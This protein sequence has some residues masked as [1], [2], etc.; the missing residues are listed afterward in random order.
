MHMDINAFLT[1]YV[2]Y[3]SARLAHIVFDNGVDSLK[4][5]F[6]ALQCTHRG[7]AT[8]KPSVR[9]SVCLSLSVKRVDCDKTKETCAHILY[10][11]K[12]HFILVFWEERLVGAT[13]STYNF[14]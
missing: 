4:A 3:T 10:H 7:L 14:R 6:T 2:C 11:M 8:R 13:P 9:L 5:L 12:D 1:V